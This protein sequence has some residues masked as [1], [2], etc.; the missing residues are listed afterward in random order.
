MGEGEGKN[1]I[2]RQRVRKDPLEVYER[3]EKQR[4][5]NRFNSGLQLAFFYGILRKSSPYCAWTGLN[6]TAMV[7]HERIRK[8]V[9]KIDQS[10]EEPRG[11]FVSWAC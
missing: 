6:R 11:I 5:D 10:E 3:K 9:G 7:D 4:F 2:Q 1:I 8:N